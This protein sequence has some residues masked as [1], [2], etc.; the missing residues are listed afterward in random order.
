MID[1]KQIPAGFVAFCIMLLI[2]TW[3][4]NRIHI[5]TRV[6]YDK[7]HTWRCAG[8]CQHFIRKNIQE[9]VGCPL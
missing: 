8:E 5:H 2:P 7:W 6:R 1:A 3:S 4:N 9:D